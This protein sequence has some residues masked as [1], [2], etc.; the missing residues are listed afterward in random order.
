MNSHIDAREC[1][2]ES[3]EIAD[4]ALLIDY[5]MSLQYFS[6]F[7]MATMDEQTVSDFNEHS[8]GRELSDLD[9]KQN[10]ESVQELIMQKSRIIAYLEGLKQVLSSHSMS[11]TGTSLWTIAQK[12]IDADLNDKDC[13]ELETSNDPWIRKKYDAYAKS[14]TLGPTAV[15]PWSKSTKIADDIPSTEDIVLL[16]VQLLL[17]EKL[18]EEEQQHC[19]TEQASEDEIFNASDRIVKRLLQLKQKPGAVGADQ[20]G[21][22]ITS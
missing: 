13:N 2:Q 19:V 11:S 5:V 7:R 1:R 16:K 14:P 9:F 4:L 3:G 18:K 10:R 15:P 6:I 22:T 12:I 21:K 8:I 17:I 20:S